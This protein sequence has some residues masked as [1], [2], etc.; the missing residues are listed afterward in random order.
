MSVEGGVFIWVWL[1]SVDPHAA[2]LTIG[3]FT[4]A[5]RP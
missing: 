5:V 1:I 3:A 4:T 2:A